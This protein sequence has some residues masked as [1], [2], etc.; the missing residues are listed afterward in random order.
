MQ[1]LLPLEVLFSETRL[2]VSIGM[3]SVPV[4]VSTNL[5]ETEFDDFVADN[6]FAVLD[7]LI[8]FN[9]VVISEVAEDDDECDD[10]DDNKDD[11]N[12]DEDPNDKGLAGMLT[13]SKINM[14]FKVCCS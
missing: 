5:S 7:K 4:E 2:E 13:E 3:F 11:A 14:F 8:I 9:F 10:D 12:N 6:G 1:H